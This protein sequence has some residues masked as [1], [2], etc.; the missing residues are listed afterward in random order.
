MNYLLLR[1]IVLHFQSL[2]MDLLLHLQRNAHSQLLLQAFE[3]RSNIADDFFVDSQRRIIVLVGLEALLA[4][5]PVQIR[6]EGAARA[7]ENEYVIR[8][9]LLLQGQEVF[10]YLVLGSL[11]LEWEV[12]SCCCNCGV[13]DYALTLVR[14]IYRFRFARLVRRRAI[15]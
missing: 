6:E 14:R 3:S 15:I 12:G 9:V 8:F 10:L 7:L 2:K 13:G 5:C 4:C 11:L 1:F